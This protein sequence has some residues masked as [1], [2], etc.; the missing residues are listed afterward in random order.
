MKTPSLHFTPFE[1]LKDIPAPDAGAAKTPRT[2]DRG[3]AVPKDAGPPEEAGR[4]AV[5]SKTKTDRELFMEAMEGVR[6][7]KEFQTAKAPA[8]P[9]PGVSKKE[10]GAVSSARQDEDLIMKQLAAIV[11]GKARINLSQT[12]EYIEWTRPGTP[13]GLAR[14]LHGGEFPVR[15]YIDLHGMTREE[16]FEAMQS[17][18]LAASRKRT[19]CVKVIHG[20][21]LRSPQGPVLKEAVRKWLEGPFR[22]YI[23]A[24]SS[25]R[26]C[27]GGPGATYVLLKTGPG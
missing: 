17:F 25:A 22:K 2:A 8:R 20:R 4:E 5:Q 19:F 6:E 16:A 12:G 21:G 3:P 13:S 7:I 1:V 9:K 26:A 24:Y 11:G 15:E 27:D 23:L 10:K 18:L 14:R